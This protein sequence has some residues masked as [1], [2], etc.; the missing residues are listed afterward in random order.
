MDLREN[1]A[2]YSFDARDILGLQ[3]IRFISI[4]GSADAS[5][6]KRPQ[7]NNNHLR[8]PLVTLLGLVQ[9]RIN[10]NRAIRTV[11][12]GF[13]T[14]RVFRPVCIC[15]IKGR[16]PIEMKSDPFSFSQVEHSA[17]GN[18]PRHAAF[19][20]SPMNCAGSI[21]RR[22]RCPKVFMTYT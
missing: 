16:P 3:R 14:F 9:I 18:C 5:W 21:G 12:V 19:C 2:G 4:C 10:T 17:T 7:W 20:N 11:E 22:G 15:R 13:A 6:G 1:W 8:S